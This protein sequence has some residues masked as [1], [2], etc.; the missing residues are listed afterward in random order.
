[1]SVSN[2]SATQNAD[3]AFQLRAIG[4]QLELLSRTYKD[5]KDEVNS[6]K[7]Q[8]SGADRRGNTVCMAV[9]NV[10]SDFEEFV[11]KNADAVI[12]F[13]HVFIYRVKPERERE[14]ESGAV[15]VTS[16][17]STVGLFSFLTMLFLPTFSQH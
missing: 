3:V 11:D 12:F 5:L 2:E 10:K 17:Q 6:I 16:T 8:N 14:R 15:G 4:Q 13:A 7:Q 1:M 9:Q